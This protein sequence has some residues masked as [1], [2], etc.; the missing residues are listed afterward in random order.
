MPI[1]NTSS[2][3]VSYIGDFNQ[4]V[5]NDVFVVEYDKDY[6]ISCAKIARHDKKTTHALRFWVRKRNHF[7][8]LKDFLEQTCIPCTFSEKTA[9]IILADQWNVS[10]LD[11][12]DDDTVLEQNLLELDVKTDPPSS[13]EDRLLVHFLGNVFQAEKLDAANLTDILMA[14]VAD[15]SKEAFKKYPVLRCCYKSKCEGWNLK[16]EE[17]WIKQV[18]SDLVDNPD[19]L[20]QE[21]SIWSILNGYPEKLL[22]YVLPPQRIFFIKKVPIEA[23]VD[24][25]L[26]REALDQAVAQIDIFYQEVKSEVTSS[27]AFQKLLTSV[28]GRLKQ[29]FVHLKDIIK[30]NTFPAGFDDIRSFQEKFKNC[31]GVT[32]GQLSALKSFVQPKRPTILNEGQSWTPQEW[33]L[34]T[35]N[36]YIPF[37]RWQTHNN[38]YDDDLEKT[39]KGF[40]DLY[41]KEYTSI[42][43][44]QDHSLV[45][46]LKTLDLGSPS[47]ELTVILLLDGLPVTFLDLFDETLGNAG[48]HRHDLRYLFAP[49][50]TTTQYSKPFLLAGNWESLLDDY[51]KT[52]KSRAKTDWNNRRI[53]YISNLKELS[54]LTGLEQSSIV[55]LNLLSTD[56][57]LH[58]DV[59]SQNTTYEEELYRLFSRVGDSLQAFLD[60]WHG[61][62]E[63]V[64]VYVITDHGA[65]QILENEKGSF[66]SAIVNKMFPEERYR[67]SAFEAKKAT[68]IPENIWEFG[69]RFEQ[70]FLSD[71]KIYFL[72]KGH[73]TVRSYGKKKCFMHGGI[74]P[75]EVIVPV[76]LYKPIKVKWQKPIAR[77][78]N[79]DVDQATGRAKFFIQRVLRLE[80]EVRNLSPVNIRILRTSVLF[81]EA[82]IKGCVNPDIQGNDQGVVKLDC[83]F[84]K[85]ALGQKDIELEITYEI[86]GQSYTISLPPLSSELKS[87]MT[88]GFS[89]KD[90]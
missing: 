52:L 71:G 34:W 18:C 53:Y 63:H 15:D 33:V 19:G 83:Y 73:N 8:W 48:L 69:Y 30:S 42:Q 4:S 64:D 80:I 28:S 60:N 59:E 72:P 26:H 7:A 75:E 49:L 54:E 87:A 31:A 10:I 17:A 5:P 27:S 13:F 12:L 43:Q 47:K 46:V 14:T 62:R 88:G 9:R 38:Q 85:S 61:S 77:F 67:F 32:V 84:K 58:S 55:L 56:E 66:D 89:L 37:R 78:L 22:E 79:L 57:L 35:V 24:V 39:V 76:A 20:W 74:T 21:L 70:P 16:T 36:E 41:L 68:E 90:L 86:E 45:N 23:V 3:E 65:C 81:P 44:N 11:W 6:V 1:Q 2:L 40:S 82:E 50:P 25:P 51:E 29:E